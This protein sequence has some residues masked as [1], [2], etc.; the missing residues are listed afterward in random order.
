MGVL[1]TSS[2]WLAGCAVEVENLQAKRELDRLA[3]PPGS[4]YTGWRVFQER[5]ADCHGP[6]ATGTAKGPDLL[7]RMRELGPRRFVSLVLQR[8]DWPVPA[9]VR[10]DAAAGGAAVEEILQR[11]QGELSMRAWQGEPEV[12]AHIADLY[13][14][15]SARTEG[16]QGPGRPEP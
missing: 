11:R 13:A 10:S 6:E 12:T 15:L 14:Y 3:R 4:I 7:P 1:M 5:C 9:Q 2:L 8:Y 16:T